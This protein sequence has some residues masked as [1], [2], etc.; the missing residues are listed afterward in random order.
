M[1]WTNFKN[2]L[3]SERRHTYWI[4]PYIV[5]ACAL[6]HVWL[7]ATPWT[8][9]RQAPL[10]TGF[11]RPEYW[12]GFPFASPEDLPDPGI[13]PGLLHCRW[14]LYP[15]SSQGSHLS[16][17]TASP[18]ITMS[19]FHHW[20]GRA[21]LS[22]FASFVQHVIENFHLQFQYVTLC[23]CVP[24]YYSH[25]RLFATPRTAD[26]QASPSMEFSRQEYCSG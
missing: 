14:I 18:N 10:S 21:R 12:S 3:V 11:S 17:I 7:F 19:P 2:I 20:G 9:A 5:C 25:V 6:S 13:N 16:L 26:C 1:S 4:T 15:L 23:V 22:Q 8:V 24:S